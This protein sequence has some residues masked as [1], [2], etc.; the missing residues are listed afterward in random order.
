MTIKWDKVGAALSLSAPSSFSKQHWPPSRQGW[1]RRRLFLLM[2]NETKHIWTAGSHHTNQD[3]HSPS[4][5]NAQQRVW[6]SLPSICVLYIKIKALAWRIWR[7]FSSFFN[8]C[9][10]SW[11]YLRLHFW[12]LFNSGPGSNLAVNISKAPFE[13]AWLWRWPHANQE[14]WS[15]PSDSSVSVLGFQACPCYESDGKTISQPVVTPPGP[16]QIHRILEQDMI[17]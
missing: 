10:S 6:F 2:V 11:F 16:L 14:Y 12:S 7:F 17:A 13:T 1:A 9:V 5:R 3:A 8:S 15:T 4:A